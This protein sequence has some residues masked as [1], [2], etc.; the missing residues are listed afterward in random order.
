MNPHK[1]IFLLLSWIIVIAPLISADVG[2]RGA[3]GV[4][5]DGTYENPI[6][7]GDSSDLDAIRVGK[8]C[9]AISSTFQYNHW[10]F[11]LRLDER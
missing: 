7:P 5:G 6:L 3:W 10:F 11:R 4:Q 8:D 1:L 9:C 2:N